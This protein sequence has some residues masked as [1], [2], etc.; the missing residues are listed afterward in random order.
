MI[1]PTIEQIKEYADSIG[2]KELDAEYFYHYY[3]A[4][5]W[6]RPVGKVLVPI[7][8]WKSVVITW[9]NRNKSKKS[10]FSSSLKPK[11]GKYDRI[12]NMQ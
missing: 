2:F 11:E 1:K 3:K 4:I 6:K 9:R 8:S 7:S 10:K 12:D 5:D